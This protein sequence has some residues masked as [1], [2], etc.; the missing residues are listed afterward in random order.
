MYLKKGASD[1]V[2]F[3]LLVIAAHPVALAMKRSALS[4][5]SDLTIITLYSKYRLN[6][7]A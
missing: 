2:T 6:E 4:Q 5:L 3:G 7:Y 1:T